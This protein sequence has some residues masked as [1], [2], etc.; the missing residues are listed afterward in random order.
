MDSSPD[1]DQ[2]QIDFCCSILLSSELLMLV[3]C[4]IYLLQSAEVTSPSVMDSDKKDHKNN[5]K[6]QN[7]GHG[8]DQNKRPTMFQRGGP[9]RGHGRGYGRGAMA[10]P[11]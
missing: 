3:N 6:N 5:D 4:A 11:R 10:R 8:N 2:S 7:K 1:V 9:E